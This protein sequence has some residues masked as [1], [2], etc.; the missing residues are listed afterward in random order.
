MMRY[1]KRKNAESV[2][3][4]VKRKYGT[5]YKISCKLTLNITYKS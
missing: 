3:N 2:F 5:V 1:H 4:M